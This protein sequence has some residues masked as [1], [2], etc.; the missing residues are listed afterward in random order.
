VDRR[1]DPSSAAAQALAAR[2]K[3]LLAGFTGDD[4]GVRRGLNKMWADRENWLEDEAKNFRM[5]A[6]VTEFIG[7][8]MGI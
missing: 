8:A 6:A 5:P 4:P 2:W 3:H 7:K 1:E